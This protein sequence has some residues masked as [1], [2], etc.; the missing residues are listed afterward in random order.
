MRRAL[1]VDSVKAGEEETEGFDEKNERPLAAESLPGL[2]E[3]EDE[4]VTD[5][6]PRLSSTREDRL[7]GEE[8]DQR[9][10][11]RLAE[12]LRWGEGERGREGA[13]EGVR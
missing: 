6:R 13:S 3:E 7:R 4:G 10:E 11:E 2:E 1:L 5:G 8:L 9:N 12:L